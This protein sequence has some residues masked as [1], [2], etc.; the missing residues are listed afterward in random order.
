MKSNDLQIQASTTTGIH[1]YSFV[2]KC[3]DITDGLALN[4]NN[5][6]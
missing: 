6:L 3:K 4:I 2:R 5:N 1:T